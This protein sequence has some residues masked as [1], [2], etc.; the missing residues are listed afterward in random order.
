MS[1]QTMPEIRPEES[2][3]VASTGT[4]LR[5]AA[6]A[7]VREISRELTRETVPAPLV[8][9][10]DL[11]PDTGLHAAW[12]GHSTVLVKADGFTLLT[13]PVF[14]GRVGLKMGPMTV[15]IKRL[16]EVAAPIAALPPVDLIVL[17]HAHMDHFDLPSL[18]RLE[19]RRTHIATAE[20]TS[21]LLRRRRYAGVHEVRWNHTVRIGPATISAF[22]VQHWGAR[23]RSDTY[24]CYNGYLIE[25]GRYRLVFG[26]DTAYTD[27]FRQVK[28]SRPV[29]LA[30]MP[31]GAYDPWIR[32]H[33]N[34]EQAWTM[35]NHA[36]A[37]FV[38]PVHHQTFKLS[39]EPHLE[40]IERLLEAAGNS[41][42]RVCV[43]EIGAEF[44]S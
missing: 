14:S 27:V 43:Q 16:V 35:A 32:V 22:R 12:L 11:W 21:D 1:S 19:N 44:H 18:R 23:L 40:P 9:R 17:S 39:R 24:R 6:P 31:I 41:P 25:I 38:L 30:I 36:G 5:R 4:F 29:N 42:E 8:P 10:P 2:V 20:L 28:T 15:G 37:D 7:F 34:P 33:C 26:G 13:D 3:R